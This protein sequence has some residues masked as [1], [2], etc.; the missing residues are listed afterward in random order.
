MLHVRSLDDIPLAKSW[1]TIG[2]FDG[3]HR[4][5]QEILQHLTAGAH[6]NGASAVV[7]N[8]HP[9]PGVILGKRTAL[10]YLSLPD[11]KAALLEKLGVDVVITYPFDE[12]VAAFP[13]D[14]FI[15]RI[16][17]QINIEKLLIGYDFAL[18][19]KRQGDA[20]YLTEI[21]GT[22]GYAVQT[23][24]P[25]LDEK[26]NIISSSRIRASLVDGRMCDAE[27]ALGHP[28]ALSGPVIHGD[29]RGRKIN[30]P[31]ANISV[32]PEKAIPA[33]GVYACWAWIGDEK[34]PAVTNV[35]I[36]PTFTPDQA[37]ANI[38]AHFLDFDGNLYDQQIRLEFISRLR[39][40]QK[41][42]SIEALLKQINADIAKAREILS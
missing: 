28:Y 37:E 32:P 27:K 16:N 11:E 12:K 31:T 4:G 25:V 13:A 35:G 8:F 39:A 22:L 33:N 30:I 1:L 14:E 10:K 34:H 2:V 29:G 15:K 40:E 9:H 38:E 24:E 6:A 20:A 36:R 7:L 23:F 19:H 17:E 18:G 21:G 42:N 41:F 5:H 26:N 3:V